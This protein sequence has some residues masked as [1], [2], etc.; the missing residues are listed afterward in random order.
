ME[1]YFVCKD[2]C[3][4]RILLCSQEVNF[5][6]DKLSETKTVVNTVVVHC[7]GEFVCITHVFFLLSKSFYG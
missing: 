5:K 3:Q 2:V 7:S 4:Q 1:V 6:K